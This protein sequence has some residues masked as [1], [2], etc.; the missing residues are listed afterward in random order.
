MRRTPRAYATGTQNRGPARTMSVQMGTGRRGSPPSHALANGPTRRTA[1]VDASTG[2]AISLGHAPGTS[3]P[4]RGT[5]VRVTTEP[6]SEIVCPV[7][8]FRK[9]ACRHSDAGNT[10]GRA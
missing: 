10:A 3:S 8:S 9:L 7:H 4:T 1:L 6:D 5:A 2:A